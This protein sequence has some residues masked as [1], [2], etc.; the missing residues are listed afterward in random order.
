MHDRMFGICLKS[1]KC[2]Q[3]IGYLVIVQ[4]SVFQKNVTFFT[5]T[6]TSSDVDLYS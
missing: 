3:V 4:Y 5:F 2:K 6:I 1:D